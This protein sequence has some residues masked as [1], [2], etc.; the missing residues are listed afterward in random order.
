MNKY[1][2]LVIRII[3]GGLFIYASIDKISDPATFA[4]QINNYHIIPFGLENTIALVLPWL[5]I[6]IGICL[7]IGV[8]VEGASGW[9]LLLL[10]S[11]I[12]FMVQAIMRGYNIECGC[13]LKEGQMIG[14]KKILENTIMSISMFWLMIQ[15]KI[16]FT[17]FP[18]TGLEE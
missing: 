13:G 12:I 9:I 4:K 6:I 15:P 8:Y 1:I 16:Y 10:I 7:I 18:K 11:F 14:L 2:Q 5:E 17:L 3:V